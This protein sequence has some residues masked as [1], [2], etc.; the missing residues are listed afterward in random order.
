MATPNLPPTLE[1]SKLLWPEAQRRQL[2]ENRR[3]LSVANGTDR[4][5][6]RKNLMFSSGGVGIAGCVPTH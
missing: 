6:Q 4:K 3:L 2:R 1:L 5:T